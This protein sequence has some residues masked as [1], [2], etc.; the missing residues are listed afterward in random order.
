[1]PLFDKERDVHVAPQD[2]VVIVHRFLHELRSW[3]VEREIPKRLQ[4]VAAE[5]DPAEAARLHAWVAYQRFTEHAIREL[6]DGTL[7]RWFQ[8]P[9]R[10]D[11]AP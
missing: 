8:G 5:A 11:D 3:A 9:H 10:D 2:A 7:D 6:E 4:R 1:M